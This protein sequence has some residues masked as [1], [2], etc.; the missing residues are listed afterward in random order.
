MKRH[1]KSN[2]SIPLSQNEA[3]S[4]ISTV[5]K[6]EQ[7]IVMNETELICTFDNQLI[8]DSLISDLKKIVQLK[9]GKL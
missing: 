5:A 1:Y 2:K 3:F 4:R 8:F 9:R 6:R 7:S